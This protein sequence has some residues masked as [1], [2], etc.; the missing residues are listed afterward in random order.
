MW[1]FALRRLVYA[2]PILIGVSIVVFALIKMAP[3]DAADLLIPPETPKEVAAQIRA[4]LGLDKPI[5]VQYGV[6]LGRMVRGDLGIS[7]VTNEPVAASLLNALG[8]TLRLAIPAP[9]PRLP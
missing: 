9:V 7:I 1:R 6:W 4:K 3:G 2:I 5:Y 8:N